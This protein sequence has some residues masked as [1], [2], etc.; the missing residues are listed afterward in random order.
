MRVSLLTTGTELLLGDVRDSH[1]SFI[2]RHLLPLG[3]RIGEQR[4]VPDGSAIQDA[5]KELFSRSD[6]LFV[7]GGL[8]PTT[9]DVTREVV[10]GLLELELVHDETVMGGIRERLKKRRI[11][12]S[13]RIGRQ[14][15]VP[16]GATVLPNANGT[17]PGFYLRSNANP[18]VTSPQLFILPGPPRE[19]QPMFIN[20]VLPILSSIVPAP[21]FQRRLYRIAN[22]GESMVEKA[23]GAKILALPGIELG[24][25]ARP[26]EVDLRVIGDEQ[27]VQQADAIIR[28]ALGDSIFSSDNENLEEVVVKSLIARGQTLALAESCTGGLLANRI[29]N[30]PGASNVFLAGYIVYANDAKIDLLDVNPEMIQQHGAVSEPVACAMADGARKRAG[31]TFAVATT[32]IAGPGGG[33]DDKPVGTVFVAIASPNDDTA[34]Q[35]LFYPNDRETF[36]QQTAQAAFDMLRRKLK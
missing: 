12:V 27:S 3:L 15:Q 30:V 18:N 4:T 20:S 1:L 2:A 11:P 16:K 23:V 35:K 34:A 13:N 25:C 10:S 33:T 24:Y 28:G 29:T 9:D 6:I 14:A 21:S 8:G 26:S 36:K 31:A 19:L 22:M 5:L 17:A 7:T 32:G